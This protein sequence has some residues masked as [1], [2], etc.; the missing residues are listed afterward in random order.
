MKIEKKKKFSLEKFEVAKFSNM[1][2]IRGGDYTV[3]TI[4][5]TGTDS[6]GDCSS[7]PTPKPNPT[8]GT[9]NVG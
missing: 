5:N 1:Y 9:I 4:T 3:D 8:P 7:R 6:S 2:L